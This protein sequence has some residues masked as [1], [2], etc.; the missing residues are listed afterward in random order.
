MYREEIELDYE[1]LRL[2]P[3][4][5]ELR[6][7]AL[8]GSLIVGCAQR[9][10]ESRGLHFNLD[11]LRRIAAQGLRAIR[12]RSRPGVLVPPFGRSL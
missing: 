3:D 1:R 5:I 4:L 8:V 10:R 9:R 12:L 7:L 2:S 6:N 11:H